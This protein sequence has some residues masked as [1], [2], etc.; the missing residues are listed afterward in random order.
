MILSNIPAA[1]VF[2]DN[3]PCEKT[4]NLGTYFTASIPHSV[5]CHTT[6]E[7][8]QWA[9]ELGIPVELVRTTVGLEDKDALLEGFKRALRLA[10]IVCHQ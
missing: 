4:P 1:M 6:V 9:T 10:E 3:L 7:E 8:K 5:V 2:L